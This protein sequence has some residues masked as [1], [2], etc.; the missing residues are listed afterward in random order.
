MQRKQNYS[1]GGSRNQSTSNR[2]YRDNDPP[3]RDEEPGPQ[4][5]KPRYKMSGRD[6]QR[7]ESYR[8]RK[9]ISTMDSIDAE[10]NKILHPGF[11]SLAN[12]VKDLTITHRT[13]RIVPVSSHAVGVI[14]RDN[15]LRTEGEIRAFPANYN[16]HSFYRVALAML[17]TK[18][19]TQYK[20]RTITPYSSVGFMDG[21]WVPA[22]IRDRC[23]GVKTNFVAFA[24]FLNSIGNITLG[25]V[26]HYVGIPSTMSPFVITLGN[27]R[28]AVTLARNAPVAIR[29]NFYRNNPFPFAVWEG[30]NDDRV[31]VNADDIMPVEYMLPQFEQ[32]LEVCKQFFES[33]NRKYP[34]RVSSSI[35]YELKGHKSIFV[36]CQGR[37][38]CA[39]HIEGFEQREAYINDDVSE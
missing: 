5:S 29:R 3:N 6:K 20:L 16:R 4:P 35:N 22:E 36:S 18:L 1:R 23:I 30:Q 38:R 10:L 13:A 25:D 9:N 27:L 39:D 24:N 26:K 2:I 17:E 19:F 15:I 11:A 37:I 21:G 8:V 14:I 31:L 33:V 28:N 32:D 7:A 12:V 34:K